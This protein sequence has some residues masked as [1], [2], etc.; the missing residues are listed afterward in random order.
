[1]QQ[2]REV[3]LEA[4]SMSATDSATSA[5]RNKMAITVEAH[6]ISNVVKVVERYGQEGCVEMKDNGW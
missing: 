3:H 2:D 4:G 5:A 1:M 6:I